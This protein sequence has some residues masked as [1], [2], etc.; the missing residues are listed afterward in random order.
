VQSCDERSP[1]VIVSP[2]YITWRKS[3]PACTCQRRVKMAH[4]SRMKMAHST[5]LVTNPSQAGLPFF[6][7][8]RQRVADS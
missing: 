6:A 2:H 8:L 1:R 3:S 5:P 4:L 7:F